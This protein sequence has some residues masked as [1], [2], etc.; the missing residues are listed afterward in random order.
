MASYQRCS[1]RHPAAKNVCNCT[2]RC[3][4]DFEARLRRRHAAARRRAGEGERGPPG[5]PPTLPP[6]ATP[7]SPSKVAI[8][9]VV[10]WLTKPAAALADPPPPKAL[11][12]VDQGDRTPYTAEQL[13]RLFSPGNYM[14]WVG[15]HAHRFWGPILALTMGLRATEIARLRE[16]DVVA[17]DG[18]WCVSIRSLHSLEPSRV[19]PIP[20][21]VIRTGFLDSVE[22][23]RM[24][25]QRDFLPTL[26]EQRV[27]GRFDPSVGGQRL[28]GA[29]AVYTM[30]FD[31]TPRRVF[32]ALRSTFIAE[33]I[34]AGASD[35]ELRDLLGQATRPLFDHLLQNDAVG[36]M[37]RRLNRPRWPLERLHYRLV[38]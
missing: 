37:A 5:N 16:S 21:A 35:A 3:E 8:E 32:R 9:V 25:G 7:R 20:D 6:P 29:F 28:A 27:Q 36:H 1:C 34:K 23:A 24:D 18:Y 17:R 12:V 33:M 38:R 10:E 31:F 26:M 13:R 22:Q 15:S 14:E 2:D 4:F 19:L 11:A 30:G